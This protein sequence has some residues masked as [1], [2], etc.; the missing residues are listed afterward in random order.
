MKIHWENFITREDLKGLK[1]N[2]GVTHLRVPLGHWIMGDIEEG[3]PWVDGEWP[4]FQRLVQWCREEGL[5]IWPDIHTAPGSQNGFDNSGQLS[6]TGPTCHGWDA[7]VTSKVLDNELPK[8]VLRS[9]KAVEDVTAAIARE[10]MTDVVTGFGVLNE[11]FVDCNIHIVKKFDNLAYKIVKKNMGKHAYV[12][13]PDLFNATKWNGFWNEET[14]M[15]TLLDSHYY[16][17]KPYF[18]CCAKIINYYYYS[19]SHSITCYFITNVHVLFFVQYL[20]NVLV[21]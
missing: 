5:Q 17:G 16:H 8:N 7:N 21:I 11:P 14:Y 19:I 9:L 13:I 2:T 3:E 10:K 6:S 12:Y 18:F 20:T 15:N 4:Y 1:Q